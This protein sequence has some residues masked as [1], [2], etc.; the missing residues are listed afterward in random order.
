MFCNTC[1]SPV[2]ENQVACGKCGSPVVGRPLLSLVEQHLKIMGVL[3][4]GYA[5]LHGLGGGVLLLVA[6][7]IFG[8]FSDHPNANFVHPLLS[9][10]GIFLLAK[11]ALCVVAG[12][13]L[14]ERQHWARALVLILAG[15]ALIN[16]P[17]GTILGVYTLWV[18]MS[19][20]ADRD[21]ERL[22]ASA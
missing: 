21:Y 14:L 18:L 13:G 2:A 1:G 19:P 11:A 16:V 15:I 6:N 3:W 9:G 4:I 7:T 22:V 8:R 12:F 20:Q 5:V 10:I 17:L